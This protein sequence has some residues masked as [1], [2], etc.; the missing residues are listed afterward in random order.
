LW[1]K[2]N[3]VA[4]TISPSADSHASVVRLPLRRHPFA[5]VGARDKW[6]L[7]RVV[8]QS[9]QLHL[10]GRGAGRFRGAQ[11]GVHLSVSEGKQQQRWLFKIRC[12]LRGACAVA[13]P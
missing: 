7:W 8:V 4:D 10:D 12:G 13:T 6:A 9:N 3:D 1:L 5:A 2:F 11:Q